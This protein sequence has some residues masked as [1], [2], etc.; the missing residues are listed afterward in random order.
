MLL[1]DGICFVRSVIVKI[2]FA[3]GCVTPNVT[4]S[5]H[6][7]GQSG[8]SPVIISGQEKAEIVLH[9]NGQYSSGIK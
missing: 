3:N 6:L 2:H 7:V 8:N 5:F 4:I 1:V 9:T